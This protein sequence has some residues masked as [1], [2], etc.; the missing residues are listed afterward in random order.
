MPNDEYDP[1]APL[2]PLATVAEL[3]L[4]METTLEDEDPRALQKLAIASGN[5][6]D[7]LRQLVTSVE[8]DTADLECIGVVDGNA[9]YL[10]PELPVREL[11][12]IKY[13]GDEDEWSIAPA[14]SYRLKQHG[15][16]EARL[17]R[18][19]NWRH[20]SDPLRITYSH[21]WVNIPAGIKG[22]VLGAAERDYLTPAELESKRLGDRSEKYIVHADG[23]SALELIALDRYRLT[24]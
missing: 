10:V 14:G 15:I 24:R 6:R 8:G 9:L 13:L 23:F 4:A 7:Y 3:A 18:G 5:V 2:A 19:V 16:L 12:S 11:T 1:D 20:G 22:A 21:G 17:G